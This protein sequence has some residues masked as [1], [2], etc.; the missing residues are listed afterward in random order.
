MSTSVCIFHFHL[1]CCVRGG[2][3]A[4]VLLCTCFVDALSPPCPVEPYCGRRTAAAV[5]ASI[6]GPS[7]A[8]GRVRNIWLEWCSR[9]GGGFLQVP[10]SAPQPLRGFPL[11]INPFAGTKA[12]Q[13]PPLAPQLYRSRPRHHCTVCDGFLQFLPPAP[14]RAE[15][16]HRP[17]RKQQ[18]FAGSACTTVHRGSSQTSAG[19]LKSLLAACL[20]INL[21]R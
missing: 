20:L 1:V 12:S 17:D 2:W 18:S 3:G 10:W 13:S 21:I 9:Q 14:S 15:T 6:L 4:R 5:A 11:L 7:E 8:P 19:M 16:F